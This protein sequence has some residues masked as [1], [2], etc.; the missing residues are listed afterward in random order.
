ME[1]NPKLKTFH[2]SLVKANYG[3]PDY[4]TFEQTLKDPAKSKTFYDALVADK[5]EMPDYETFVNDLGLK[6]KDLYETLGFG[7]DLVK[8][9][10]GE[11]YTKEPKQELEVSKKPPDSE[12]PITPEEVKFDK[13]IKPDISLKTPDVSAYPQV[14]MDDVLAKGIL[15]EPSKKEEPTFEAYL[16]ALPQGFNQRM[17]EAIRNMG[18]ILNMPKEVIKFGVKKIGGKN[19]SANEELLNQTFSQL[20]IIGAFS[21]EN[22]N[23]L[24]N[25]IE[26]A[27]NPKE[28]P[29]NVVGKTLGATGSILFDIATIRATP[30]SKINAL[31]KYGMERVPMF[32]TYLATMGGTTAAREGGG[33]KETTKATAEGVASGLTYEGIGVT[34]GRIG[35]LVKELGGTQA[36]STSS[37]A[38][39]NSVM[40]G[41]DSKVKGG[42][43]VEG[44]AMGL[45]FGG[46]DIGMEAINRSIAHRAYISYLTTTDNGIKTISKMQIDPIKL[47]KQSDEL[48]TQY[49]SL[50]A[51][52]VSDKDIQYALTQSQRE[53]NLLNDIIKDTE[54]INKDFW[55]KRK[56]LLGED[57]AQYWENKQKNLDPEDI[58]YDIDQPYY[59]K[60]ANI[61]KAIKK[62]YLLDE[63]TSI[64]NILNVNA[65]TQE[66]VKNPKAFIDNINKDERLSA[67]EKK[68]WT[69]KINT[70]VK[71]AD[72]R[73]AEAEPIVEDI[74]KKESELAYW[75]ENESTDPMIKNAKM[76]S[77]TTQIEEQNKALQNTLAKPLD[78]YAPKK[79]KVSEKAPEEEIKSP[80]EV[81]AQTPEEIAKENDLEYQGQQKDENGVPV[82]DM[83]KRNDNQANL[84]VPVGSDAEAVKKAME[85]KANAK[86]PNVEEIQKII[87]SKKEEVVSEEVKDE[88]VK[89]VTKK[90][91]KQSAIK[92]DKIFK[93]QKNQL[94]DDLIAAED[95]LLGANKEQARKLESSKDLDQEFKDRNIPQYYEHKLDALPKEVETK[96][97][98]LGIKVKEGKLVVDIYKD[99]TVEVGHIRTA[100]R[101]I[102]KGF[103]TRVKAVSTPSGPGKL[104]KS[105][106]RK[107]A[108]EFTS[109]AESENRV[110]LAEENL[111][112][113]KKSG[114]KGLTKVMEEQLAE[115]NAIHEEAK[116]IGEEGYNRI[117]KQK[118]MNADKE[119]GSF[120]DEFKGYF[121]YGDM[122]REQVY[123]VIEK[124]GRPKDL[125]YDTVQPLVIKDALEKEGKTIEQKRAEIEQRLI[126]AEA[127]LKDKYGR[128]DGS[129]LRKPKGN[130]E[131]WEQRTLNNSIQ[132]DRSKLIDLQKYEPEIKKLNEKPNEPN[133]TTGKTGEN[134]VSG[135]TE[136]GAE[137]V[138]AEDEEKPVSNPATEVNGV[139][140]KDKT[141]QSVDEV[142][143]AIDRGEITF[144]ESKQL[145]EDVNKFE[146]SQPK[147]G[148]KGGGVEGFPSTPR[149]KSAKRL[150]IEPKAENPEE[151][152]WDQPLPMS[153]KEDPNYKSSD[154][155]N[156]MSL[157]NMGRGLVKNIGKTE[158][159]QV[160]TGMIKRFMR[161]AA[162]IFNPESGVI[163]VKNISDVRVLAH[164]IGHYIDQF[165]FDIRGVIGYRA[166]V[167]GDRFAD[168]STAMKVQGVKY[169]GRTY[170]SEE[171]IL[172]DVDSQRIK[173]AKGTEL[174]NKLTPQIQARDLRLVKLR[175][176]YGNEIVDGVLQRN[177]FK[178]ELTG[179]LKYVGYP[180]DKRTEA[181]AEF[182]KD[183]VVNPD[184]VKQ[185]TPKF[186]AWFEKLIDNAPEIKTALN[187]ARE[188]WNKYDAQ[189]PRTKV[190]TLFSQPEA[191]PSFL[192]GIIK[193]DKDKILYS[194]VNH[195]Q[196]MKNLSEEWRK[197]VGTNAPSS[198]D[199]FYAAKSMMG[200][201]GRAQQW[202][203][204]RPYSRKENDIVLKKDIEGL[205]SVLNPIIGTP[206]DMDF[207]GYLLA[208]DSMEAYV[209]GHPEKAAMPAELARTSI[210]LWEKQYG[211]K[212]L[213]EF[214]GKIQK[215]NEEL[216]HFYVECGMIS[217][218]V[219]D[220][221]ISQHQYYVPL[222]RVF[223]E[224]EVG[225][226]RNLG[227]KDVLASSEKALWSRHGSMKAIKDI[228][229]S[230]IENTYQI[231]AS[232]ER[233]ILLN[234][235]K[236]AM[237]DIQKYNRS[238]KIDT[239]IIEEI[240]PNQVKAYFDVT[241]GEMRYTIIKEKPRKGRI[242][243]VWEDG[244]VH[245]YDVAPEYYDPIFQQEPKVTELF[246]KLSIPS[247][248]LQAGAVVYDPT[249]PIRN[250]F[251]DQQSAWFYSKYNYLP[252][253]FVKGIAS[254]IGK[255]EAYQKW[256][257]SGGDQSFLVSA[258]QMMEKD[259]AKKKIGRTLN[260][261]WETYKR[262][263]LAALQD[264][265]RASEIGTRLGAFKNAY[266]KTNDVWKAAVES[267]DISA[268]YGIHGATVRSALGM[269]P[270][271]NA[272]AQHARM[273]VEAM[274]NP[275]SFF[276]K[277]MAI[278]APALAN[279]L[280]NNQDEES[281]KL[282]QSLPTWRRVG[283]FNIRIPG[284]DHFLPLPKGFFGVAFGSSV[285]AFMDSMLKDDSRVA[286]E[287]PKE[288][289]SQF[290]P[291]GNLTE[292]VPFIV[293]PGIE[294]WANK[295][296]YTGKPII[297]ESMRMLKPSE[298]YYNSTPEIFKK[299]GEALNWSPVKINHYIKSYTG[300]AGMGAVNI[301]DET[302]QLA[303]L[304]DKKPEDSFTTLSRMPVFKALLTERPIG[305]QSGYISD[306]YETLDKVEKLNT[307]FNNLVKTENYEKLDK[308]MADPDNQRMYSFYE[309]N[310]TAINNFRASLTWIR[311][312]GYAVMKDDM[313]T[314]QEKQAEVKQMND[315]VQEAALRFKDAYDNNKFFDYGKNMDEIIE[316]MKESK[317]DVR[318]DLKQQQNTY[319]PYWQMLRKD[320]K[321]IFDNIKEYGGFKELDQRVKLT[322]ENR[323]PIDL[324][325]EKSRLYNEKLVVNYGRQVRNLL[326]ETKDR[327]QSQKSKDSLN[328]TFDLAW[329]RAKMVTAQEFFTKQLYKE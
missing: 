120:W 143:D 158:G 69:D 216:I 167:E 321:V 244:K 270:F 67:K 247:R 11:D 68:L 264:L 94:L 317:K 268:D 42:T 3:V 316:K 252:T 43:F 17:G 98:K 45:V 249:F 103:P 310:S 285:E 329:K 148:G 256:L 228:Y 269:Y 320:N 178:K 83:Y 60:M 93:E 219:G 157:R 186:Y 190:L 172:A 128:K 229:Q 189:D 209:Q 144:E 59:E 139:K 62:Q 243:S 240:P 87:D 5:Y 278:T 44:A 182:V 22:M 13:F 159:E 280:W 218:E 38:L 236:D 102:D 262:N 235:V 266:R 179:Y 57:P 308:L 325:I 40:F 307:T 89:T 181:I 61:T 210:E 153:T 263:P 149:G 254:F 202:L 118:K 231:L 217:K 1:D 163:R 259:Y 170:R 132:K 224:Y 258:D 324:S 127:E 237:M 95:I 10:F 16:T 46:Y 223:D 299:L 104:G 214:Q 251:R 166:K 284:T 196:Y 200:I 305:L 198:K 82:L 107:K 75:Q 290:S 295:Q 234:N 29:N 326:G 318:G 49:E 315:I 197:I 205:V 265:S 226:G 8:E 116:S 176:K 302:L 141:Y 105:Q 72:P 66:I 4:N 306:F 147:K 52:R 296:G 274:K 35:Q 15:K 21:Q 203:L 162:G 168:V 55:I 260:R 211:R 34:A 212:D 313:L 289:F 47:R 230:M 80:K 277:G 2:E 271:L 283:M 138:K 180:S 188:D 314:T 161:K 169:K 23:E 54:T 303:G 177:E 288:L 108:E 192:D 304:V 221:I 257:A 100:L 24:A 282:Y 241:T 184:Q 150:K 51:P 281:S 293:R 323:P 146:T 187:T 201:D 96:L 207:R 85:E 227:S 39:A 255:D 135:G 171:A 185:V 14:T 110:K 164:E 193:L 311:D 242:L 273:T 90:L 77:V 20:P 292:F 194:W 253:D 261:K 130:K 225:G 28:I 92:E 309:G 250:I 279:W 319:S 113:A 232:G 56:E 174:I 121:D 140:F 79:E 126:E 154:L 119:F 222:K 206:K 63:K 298:Q 220:L 131:E 112:T 204:H 152:A 208:M 195:L 328:D 117:A 248:W 191:K 37:K 137:P 7:R 245:Y 165:A 32:P 84:S 156:A 301:L 99:G 134:I 74:K 97:N 275:V 213:L 183:Y 272:R 64:D 199:P 327:Y 58:E 50:E 91:D 9:V 215:Y 136:K 233:N 71:D 48:W 312:A 18:A 53:L 115:V 26:K 27:G 41:A 70:T 300:G 173:E 19:A 287:L 155:N 125:T 73:I 322:M 81:K 30:T 129:G 33:L 6:K 86:E 36:L 286:Q 25:I 122:N 109:L 238:K 151:L 297:S 175:E 88:T 239:S 65:I 111:A 106:F 76:E 101:I 145:R 246:R 291:I 267:R 124:Q 114:N 123:D 276:M 78:D 31:A 294:M 142:L 12:L 133:I 160:R